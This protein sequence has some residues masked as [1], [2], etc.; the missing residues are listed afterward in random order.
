MYSLQFIHQRKHITYILSSLPYNGETY[1]LPERL[2]PLVWEIKWELHLH[3]WMDTKLV[4]LFSMNGVCV[5]R[6][7][8]LSEM[9][10]PWSCIFPQS[11]YATPIQEIEKTK[12]NCCQT[13]VGKNLL[14]MP[15]ACHFQRET[16]MFVWVCEAKAKPSQSQFHE[17][18]NRFGTKTF[19]LS[20][21][22]LQLNVGGNFF[23][24]ISTIS[25]DLLF[26]RRHYFQTSFPISSKKTSTVFAFLISEIRSAHST[27]SAMRWH[28]S[29]QCLRPLK[30]TFFPLARCI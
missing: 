20:F 13:I 27:F 23:R 4:R 9:S 28:S 8:R 16:R 2:Y 12:E 14:L 17:Y 18:S 10:S 21:K 7:I 5:V 1:P 15:D 3:T 26:S 25:L 30:F 22:N 29:R 19:S 24:S 6:C 11:R